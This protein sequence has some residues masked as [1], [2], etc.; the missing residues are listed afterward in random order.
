MKILILST[1]IGDTIILT[2]NQQLL[3]SY[4]RPDCCLREMSDLKE[5]YD[6][7]DVKTLLCLANGRS[8]CER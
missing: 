7:D 8:V 4:I 5:S 2:G 3:E 1:P 6:F